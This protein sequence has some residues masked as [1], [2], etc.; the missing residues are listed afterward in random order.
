MSVV[1]SFLN[2]KGGVGKST[3]AYNV[4]CEIQRSGTKTLI[5]DT[6]E[7]RSCKEWADI[8]GHIPCIEML[9]KHDF[10]HFETTTSGYEVVIIDGRA[11][12]F[13]G[14]DPDS[15]GLAS[16]TI[17][18]STL[19]LIPVLPSPVDIRA[20]KD[21][22]TLVHQVREMRGDK[23]P[24]YFIRNQIKT[25]TILSREIEEVLEEFHLPIAETKIRDLQDFRRSAAVGTGVVDFNADSEASRD[26]RALVKEIEQII[27]REYAAAQPVAGAA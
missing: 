6:D 27:E 2:Q 26:I 17:Y 14:K 24:A 15:L 9:G 10:K 7:Q 18:A 8:Q 5:V 21:F 13:Q 19:V 25:G 20:S 4:A 22:V 1:I 12:M 23:P 16:K 3:L 11:N